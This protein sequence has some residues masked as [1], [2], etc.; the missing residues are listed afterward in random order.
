ML[1]NSFSPHYTPT[2]TANNSADINSS[3]S[4]NSNNPNTQNFNRKNNS[5]GLSRLFGNCGCGCN[6]EDQDPCCQNRGISLSTILFFVLIF[7]I[8]F[9]N[10]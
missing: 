9:Y 3:N 7:L 4:T 1:L 2:L 5:T 10:D 6:Q 8:L